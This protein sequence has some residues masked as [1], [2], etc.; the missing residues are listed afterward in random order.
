M[1][2]EI[3]IQGTT[4]NDDPFFRYKMEEVLLLPKG[5]KLEFSNAE[6]IA[7]SLCRPVTSL[8]TFLKKHFG[9]NF[10]FKNKIAYTT[11]KDLTIAELQQAIF[12][13]IEM[14]V[15]C[16]ICKNP[17]TKQITNKKKSYLVCE[18]CGS[19]SEI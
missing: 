15:L 10:E 6:R 14:N 16:T 3:N 1:V 9:A 8:M 2:K 18:S 5:S 12:L 11:K 19:S 13:Y 17:E 7:N 4:Q